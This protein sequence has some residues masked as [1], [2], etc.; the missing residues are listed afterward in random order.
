MNE[1]I[2]RVL[3]QVG[4]I[5]AATVIST[6]VDEIIKELKKKKEESISA[7]KEAD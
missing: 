1:V 4:G 5:I 3:K 7:L 6:A 2:I